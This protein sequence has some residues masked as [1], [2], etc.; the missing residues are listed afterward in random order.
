MHRGMIHV[1]LTGRTLCHL[2]IT[3]G[4]AMTQGYMLYSSLEVIVWNHGVNQLTLVVAAC[5]LAMQT[6]YNLR[7][8][9][10]TY[11]TV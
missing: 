3:V 8:T 11:V 4:F 9:Q 1:R 10:H 5:E 7:G 6:M 2:L